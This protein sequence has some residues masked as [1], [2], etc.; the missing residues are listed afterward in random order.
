M[1]QQVGPQADPGGLATKHEDVAKRENFISPL[2][3]PA[4]RYTAVPAGGTQLQS[5]ATM[6]EAS[7]S[8]NR[9]LRAQGCEASAA[10]LAEARLEGS[11]GG[12]ARRI[13]R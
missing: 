8:L 4:A 12:Q 2:D 11:G 6:V 1:A 9:L 10:P 3:H 5:P 13:N 7:Q